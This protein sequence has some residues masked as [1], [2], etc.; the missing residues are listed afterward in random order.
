MAICEK[1]YMEFYNHEQATITL[2]PDKKT[3]M[4]PTSYPGMHKYVVNAII[5]HRNVLDN[6]L[7]RFADGVAVLVE[8]AGLLVET[9]QSGH[10][11]L[12]AG[13]GGSAA[14][15]QHFA[16]ELVGRF[17]RERAP[18]AVLSL[19][20]DTSILTAVGNDYG[21]Q[22]VFA[23][24]VGAFGQAG[25]MLIAF[26]T[27]GESEN[28]LRAAEVGKEQF[29]TV[30]AITGE[31]ASRLEALSDLTLRVPALDTAIAQELHMIV[32]HILCDIA[33]TELSKM[34]SKVQPA[35]VVDSDGEGM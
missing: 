6:A 19:T 30:I 13:N 5:Q 32:T 25:D 20:T 28:L 22:E 35:L 24:Q 9:L 33:E 15:A 26:S 31:R 27:S 34:A 21:Y 11:V 18:Y 3:V 29:M 23:R 17:K 1:K 2:L 16:A 7:N 8:V 14:E 12:V 10:K 4:H